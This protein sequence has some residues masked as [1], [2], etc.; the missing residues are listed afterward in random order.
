MNDEDKLDKVLADVGYI[1][2]MLENNAS[3]GQKGAMFRIASLET[4]VSDIEIKDK[5]RL[6]KAGAYGGMITLALYWVGRL[7]LKFI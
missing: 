7:I 4:R 3:T 2:G 5:I 1:K 6:G